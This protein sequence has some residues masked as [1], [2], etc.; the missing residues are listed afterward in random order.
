[1]HAGSERQVAVRSPIELNLIR[2]VEDLVVGVGRAECQQDPVTD[3]ESNSGDLDRLCHRA[4][5]T[6]A[7]TGVADE[8]IN[9]SRKARVVFGEP[10]PLV[11][12]IVEVEEAVGDQRGRSVDAAVEEHEDQ[13]DGEVLGDGF[14]VLF[15]AQ[16]LLEHAAV[17]QGARG[18][19]ER[20]RECHR[21]STRR[22]GPNPFPGRRPCAGWWRR[23]P[24][25][26][27]AIRGSRG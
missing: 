15:A 11:A 2:I 22:R 18:A 27:E 13:L 19:P 12:V 21:A 9:R 16:K 24:T 6:R 25:G 23:T 1:M 8:L 7:R 10:F 17:V 5:H 4:G 20:W 14:T 26:R 3:V